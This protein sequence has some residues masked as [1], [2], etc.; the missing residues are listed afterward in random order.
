MSRLLTNGEKIILASGSP[1]RRAYF[2]DLGLSFTVSV[3]NIEEKIFPGESP[4]SYIER[5]AYSKA[6]NVAEKNPKQ[7]I[8]AADTVVCF[9]GM[10]LE[11][12]VDEEDAISM[13]L[14]LSGQEHVVK[15]SICLLNREQS[16]ADIRSVSTRVLFWKFPEDM[17]RAYVE[18]GE[19]LDKAGSYGIQGK[20][21][22]LVR[23]IHGSYSNVVGL[24]LCEFIEM[25]SH[26][27]LIF[28]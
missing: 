12:P 18:T 19:P 8:V 15:T 21:G 5:L 23:E 6:G 4:V 16:V 9:E 11:K 10:V 2:E 20:G 13:L 22:S 17:A 14:R 26:R 25:L 28:Q 24:P 1:R 27:Q 7:W 3:A